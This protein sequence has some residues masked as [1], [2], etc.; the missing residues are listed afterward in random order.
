M[1]AVIIEAEIQNHLN[2]AILSFE[3]CLLTSQGFNFL[4]FTFY[5]LLFTFLRNIKNMN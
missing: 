2:P 5:F 3:F 4:L 1:V